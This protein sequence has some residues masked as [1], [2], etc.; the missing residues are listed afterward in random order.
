MPAQ[1]TVTTARD[2]NG[3]RA[4]NV[5]DLTTTAGQFDD[6][7]YQRDR[8]ATNVGRIHRMTTQLEGYFVPRP[9]G[10]SPLTFNTNRIILCILWQ[11]VLLSQHTL[12]QFSD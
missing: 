10:N 8:A 12:W 11:K 5:F 1:T 6:P 2:V 3:D 7:S 4:V 9:K